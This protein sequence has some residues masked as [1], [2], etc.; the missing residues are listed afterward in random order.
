M[1]VLFVALFL[2]CFCFIRICL[3]PLLAVIQCI[4]YK[5]VTLESK[6]YVLDAQEEFQYFTIK[7]S[8]VANKMEIS[9]QLSECGLLL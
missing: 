8:S 2:L 6:Q 3:F 1:V 5:N 9:T 7:A 4:C